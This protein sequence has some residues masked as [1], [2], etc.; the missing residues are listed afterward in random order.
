MDLSIAI[1]TYNRCEILLKN[2]ER[3]DRYLNRSV[4]EVE[5]IVLDDASTDQ[6][7]SIFQKL[8]FKN[9]NM[10]YVRN[11]SNIGLE[12]SLIKVGR[13]ATGHYLWIFGDDD[14]IDLEEKFKE[15]LDDIK[16]AEY[17][18]FIL[19]RSRRN[20]DYSQL[21]SCDWMGLSHESD[22]PYTTL[23]DFF[24]NWGFISI[25]GFISV[26]VFK[27]VPFYSAFDTRFWGTMYPQLGMLSVAFCSSPILVKTAPIV[28]QRT[29]TQQE[30]CLSFASKALERKFMSS[31]AERNSMYF[32][33]PLCRMLNTIVERS[34]LTYNE[35]CQIREHTVCNGRLIDFI[36]LN[37]RNS[38]D[39]GEKFE[40]TEGGDPEVSKFLRGIQDNLPTGRS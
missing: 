35:I 17:D 5:V 36:L 4:V 11:I 8:T 1:P 38:G 18:F 34:A 20:S 15:F 27:R 14:Y 40:P 7:H 39:I 28:C 21:I 31:V 24:L 33:V 32:G 3:L 2:L 30:K 9:L 10:K 16:R 12:K 19:N 25:I 23:S 29:L 37:L 6:T 13:H 26:C 22:K